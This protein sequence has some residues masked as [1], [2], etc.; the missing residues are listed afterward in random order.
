MAERITRDEVAHVAMLARLALTEAELDTYTE[1]LGAVLDHARDTEALDLADVEPMTH[2]YPLQNALRPDV[3]TA[4][5]DRA[6]VLAAAPA[7]ED[8]RLLVPP[9]LGEAP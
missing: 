3:V 6:E 1:Q 5:V 2:P 9:I 7:V 8:N 4:T